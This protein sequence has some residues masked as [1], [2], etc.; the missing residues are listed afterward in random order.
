[1]IMELNYFLFFFPLSLTKNILSIT[2]FTKA[3][4]NIKVIM[5]YKLQLSE[6][7]PK[8]DRILSDC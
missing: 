5:E 4:M 6:P 1:M 8:F 3:I 7:I 2:L